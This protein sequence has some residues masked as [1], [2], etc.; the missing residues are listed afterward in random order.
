MSHIDFT[1]LSG[2]KGEVTQLDIDEGFRGE[3]D[4]CPVARAL[5]R[6]FPGYHA[7]VEVIE[8]SITDKFGKAL[9]WLQIGLRLS[10]WIA[11]FDDAVGV[12]PISIEITKRTGEW[13]L[14]VAD[15]VEDQS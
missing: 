14:E 8:A 4:T 12:E 13:V 9:V 3:C 11:A 1:N 10:I 15:D 7:Y 2:M 5:H 6:M